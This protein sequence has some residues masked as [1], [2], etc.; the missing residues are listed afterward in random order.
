MDFLNFAKESNAISREH[1]FWDGEHSDAE[2][3]AL[4]HSE[5]TEA[6]DSNRNAEPLYWHQCRWTQT[7][8]AT[9]D[10]ERVCF[11]GNCRRF[12]FDEALCAQHAHPL[13]PDGS[14]D[15]DA[16]C[17]DYNPKPE[18]WG[19]ELIDGCIRILDFM[20]QKCGDNMPD[21][22]E[23]FHHKHLGD[24]T[25]DEVRALTLPELVNWLH[26]MTADAYDWLH[27][28][29]TRGLGGTDDEAHVVS[30]LTRLSGDVD[31][32]VKHELRLTAGDRLLSCIAGSFIWLRAHGKDPEALIAEKQAYN[33]GRNYLHGK[34]Y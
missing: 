12:G 27:G 34:M 2:K 30:G 3:F 19:V 33:A 13:N 23:F 24:Y 31:P 22:E 1:G 16:C 29:W 6:L 10:P 15:P 21:P 17:A 28:L 4:I 25:P 7:L 18:G 8:G 26:G 14:G 11:A 9:P 5:W 20:Y 32:N